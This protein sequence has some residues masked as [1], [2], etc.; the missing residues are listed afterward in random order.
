M[1]ISPA[2]TVAQTPTAP[3]YVVVT[4]TSTG[5]DASIAS[6]RVYFQDAYG[7]YVV[8]SG[9]STSYVEWAYA[10]SSITINLLTTDLAVNVTVQWLDASNVVLYTLSEEYCLSEYNQQFF[11]YLLQNLALTP[12]IA[13]DANYFS[14]MSTYWMNI[15]G[16]QQ[17]VTIGAD[18]SASQNSIN[19]ADIMR[20]NENKYF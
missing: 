10:D 14:N 6:R 17:A 12:S 18:I 20:N 19:R 16:A 3:A 7:N 4:D 8:P 9:T 2:F 1:A 5:S 15:I 11:Y 13:Q